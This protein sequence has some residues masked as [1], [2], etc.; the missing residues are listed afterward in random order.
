[1]AEEV[2]GLVPPETVSSSMVITEKVVILTEAQLNSLS[3]FSP[4]IYCHTMN[5][6]VRTARNVAS[7]RAPT[8]TFDLEFAFFRRRPRDALCAPCTFSL[9]FFSMPLG[10]LQRDFI[11]TRSLLTIHFSHYDQ[12][13]LSR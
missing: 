12:V 3:T 7:E 11:H 10:R 9:L 2:R 4:T 13:P 8:K 6:N 5:I 1:M